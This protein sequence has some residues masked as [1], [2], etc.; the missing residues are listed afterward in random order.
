MT[1]DKD[2]KITPAEMVA[3]TLTWHL[4]ALSIT[5]TYGQ[6]DAIRKKS[7]QSWRNELVTAGYR[8]I[9]KLPM[10]DV[11]A[12]IELVLSDLRA[13]KK[14]FEAALKV[15]GPFTAI[16]NV[17]ND[18]AGILGGHLLTSAYTMAQ[19]FIPYTGWLEMEAPLDVLSMTAA[20]AKAAQEVLEGL[21]DRKGK[22]CFEMD[23][24]P[25]DDGVFLTIRLNAEVLHRMVVK[26]GAKRL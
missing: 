9:A 15:L 6:L 14:D 13:A 20:E 21:R 18:L 17:F 4:S 16:A 10:K 19:S 3:N 8:D 24:K 22:A 12:G 7:A 2:T 1:S 5:N 23:W 11:A 25:T 26:K